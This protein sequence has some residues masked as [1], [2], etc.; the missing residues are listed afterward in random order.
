MLITIVLMGRYLEHVAKGRTS[1][2]LTSL[3]ALQPTSAI[4]LVTD[5]KHPSV[6]RPRSVSVL[7]RSHR[8]PVGR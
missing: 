1:E 5:K 3:L 4:L 6:V 2:A 7:A 8:A